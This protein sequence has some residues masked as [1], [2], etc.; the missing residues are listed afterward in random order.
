MGAF[1]TKGDF[2]TL[3]GRNQQFPICFVLFLRGGVERKND[4]EGG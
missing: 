1:E 2:A 4:W 3:I